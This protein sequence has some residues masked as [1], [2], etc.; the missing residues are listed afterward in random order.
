MR[1][2]LRSCRVLRSRRHALRRRRACGEPRGLASE[3]RDRWTPKRVVEEVREATRALLRPGDVIITRPDIAF[4]NVFLP[5]FWPHAALHIGSPAEAQELGIRV[6]QARKTRWSA[7]LRTLEALK[8][9]VRLRSLER[10]L[11]VDAFAILRP[12][13][14]PAQIARGIERALEHEGKPYNFDFDFFRSDKL[15]CTEVIYRAFDGIGDFEIPLGQQHGRPALSAE[16]LLDLALDTEL[17]EA[18]G[19]F[20][21]DGCE[22]ELL[23]GPTVRE[24]LAESYRAS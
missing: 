8:D 20:G 22:R 12:K 2:R 13:L 14:S 16:D 7:E 11:S 18:I 9:G 6:D 3:L 10:T 5:G 19:L 1:R 15:V 24:R 17:F 21:V 4:T 23:L